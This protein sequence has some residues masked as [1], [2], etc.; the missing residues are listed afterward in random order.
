MYSIFLL[1]QDRFLY[2]SFFNL[3]IEEPFNEK[4]ALWEVEKKELLKVWK[5]RLLKA[6]KNLQ[7]DR[8]QEKMSRGL[9]VPE[10]ED[11]F[12]TLLRRLKPN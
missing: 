4:H 3:F 7:A 2:K 1:E 6:L 12:W 8:P 9:Y 5:K 11:W 10:P